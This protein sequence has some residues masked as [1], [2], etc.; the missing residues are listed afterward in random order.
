MNRYL[1]QKFSD[2]MIGE[3]IAELERLAAQDYISENLCKHGCMA[4][5]L[6]REICTAEGILLSLENPVGVKISWTCV[7]IKDTMLCITNEKWPEYSDPLPGEI[8]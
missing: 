7:Q 3:T 4:S 5:D 1:V 2:G 8:P 6:F